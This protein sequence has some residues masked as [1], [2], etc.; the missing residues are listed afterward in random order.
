MNTIIQTEQSRQI[1]S[2]FICRLHAG[3]SVPPL[4]EL[5][6]QVRGRV[7]V[8]EVGLEVCPDSV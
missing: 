8:S 5:L 1:R 3:V 4:V 6:C 7:G 2:G